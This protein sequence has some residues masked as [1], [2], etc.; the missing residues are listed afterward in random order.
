MTLI[1]ASVGVANIMFVTVRKRTKEIGIKRAIGAKKSLIKT[2][3]II[4]ALLI[5][6]TGG[7]LGGSVAYVIIR[8]AQS[9]PQENADFGKNMAM[10]ILSSPSFPGQSPSVPVQ[11]WA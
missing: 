8:L 6:L 9:I 10:Q 5:D 7:F 1:I 4:E 11:F 2:Q 3:F